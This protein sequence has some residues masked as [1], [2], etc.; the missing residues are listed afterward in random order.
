MCSF[1]MDFVLEQQCVHA[2]C[3]HIC[4]I[5]INIITIFVCTAHT[6]LCRCTDLTH[7]IHSNTVCASFIQP[8]VVIVVVVV[9]VVEVLEELL[10]E[11]L[12][13]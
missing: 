13:E 12:E 8:A 5:V 1:Q 10:V 7:S 6:A 3:L 4:T 2:T 11:W 9:V